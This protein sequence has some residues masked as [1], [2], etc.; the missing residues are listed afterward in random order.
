MNKRNLKALEKHEVQNEKYKIDNN[1]LD[2][3][4]EYFDD[5]EKLRSG[6]NCQEA[7]NFENVP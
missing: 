2:F 1:K 6:T 4:L 5:F 3:D 7:M